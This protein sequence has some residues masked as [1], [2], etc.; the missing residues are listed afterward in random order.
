MTAAYRTTPDQTLTTMPPGIPYIIGNEAAERFSFYGMKAILYLYLT[1]YIVDAAGNSAIYGKEDATALLHLFVAA[2]YLFPII[3]GPLAD[4]YL[5]KYRVILWLSWA[6]CLGH[7]SLAMI[8]G[9]NGLWLGLGLI[10]I[11][12]GGIKPCV[13]SHVGDQFGRSN[14][15]L[16]SRVFRWFYFVINVGAFTSMAMIPRTRDIFLSPKNGEAYLYFLPNAWQD[17][18]FPHFTPALAH[19]IAFGLPGI[20]M[21]VATFVFWLGRNKYVHVPPSRDEFMSELEPIFGR[22]PILRYFPPMIFVAIFLNPENRRA[23]LK[24]IPLFLFIVIFW[25]LFD[26]TMSTWVEQAT[27]MEPTVFRW[28]TWKW[29]MLPD[30]TQTFNPMFVLLFI[31]LFD[32]LLFPAVSKVFTLTPLR[33]VSIGLFL[34]AL[35][36][37]ASAF[38]QME[39]DQVGPSGEHFQ[40]WIMWLV[41]PYAIITSAEILVSTTCLEFSYTQAPNRLKSIVMSLYL[42]S[43]FG[44]NLLTS[45]INKMIIREDGSSMLKGSSYYW[46]FAGMM[47]I[48]ALA[49]IP[50]AMLYRE[51]RFIQGD[52][53][54]ANGKPARK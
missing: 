7:L 35:A 15:H 3:G 9:R 19:H 34:A 42:M 12:A 27:H 50:Y 5:G 31:P 4:F 10:A 53:G 45:V 2:A 33:R 24:L 47:L 1:R 30:E 41:V 21:L 54:E 23:I 17:A 52:N 40:P 38:I 25:A 49:F 11:G 32:L 16:M 44:G 51:S 22:F 6:Y 20:L 39:I 18:L 36:F 48:A 28:G 43:V 13:S 14:Q 37:A 46:F 8:D 29:T 26:Q